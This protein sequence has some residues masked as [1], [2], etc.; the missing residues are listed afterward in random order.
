MAAVSA[1]ADMCPGGTRDLGE[2]GRNRN[3]RVAGGGPSPRREAGRGNCKR[4]G[5]LGGALPRCRGRARVSRWNPTTPRRTSWARPSALPCAGLT[6]F[7]TRART[8]VRSARPGVMPIP[9]VG[10]NRS[11]PGLAASGD[12]VQRRGAASDRVPATHTQ[13]G[14]RT[15]R[16]LR[17]YYVIRRG[18][19]LRR[20][21]RDHRRGGRDA[22]DAHRSGP[23]LA[24]AERLTAPPARHA[25]GSPSPARNAAY[26]TTAPCPPTIHSPPG[27]S[28]RSSAR[29]TARPGRTGRRAC[30]CRR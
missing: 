19:E 16:S 25:G 24:R 13:R 4:G 29:A 7:C 2:S 15:M 9:V 8:S 14:N 21:R 20:P 11:R 26:G 12:A 18:R 10:T 23:P 6:S 30:T 28:P 17:R 5:R 3:G 22:S 27:R 1:S